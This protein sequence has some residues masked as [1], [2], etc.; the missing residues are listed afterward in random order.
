[1]TQQSKT[2]SIDRALE[3]LECFL[4]GKESLTLAE[5]SQLAN[6]SATTVLRILGALQAKGFVEKDEATKTYQL[7]FKISQ[8]SKVANQSNEMVLKTISQPFMQDLLDKY[9]EDIRLFVEQGASKLCI[10]SLE[11][12]RS[13][14][15]I[16]HVGER[17]ELIRGA[18]G[19]V[20]LAHIKPEKCDLLIKGT[21]ID[22]E[23]LES[24]REKGYAVSYGERDEGI[25]GIAA[26]ILNA[27]DELV[28]VLSLS[29]PAIRFDNGALNEKI[30]DT[31]KKAKEI[32]EAYV[33][34]V[35]RV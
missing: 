14:R 34:F 30:E 15:H 23:T 20:V 27:V 18:T 24:I 4:N 22:L 5:L 13:L 10:M 28:A 16:V 9:N 1:M 2:R 3:I 17:H 6:L 35:G 32:S 7:G 29:G 25:I 26:P 21:D 11:S 31:V 33:R 19:K 8:L 12:T